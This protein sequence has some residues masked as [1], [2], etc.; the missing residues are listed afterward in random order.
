MRR[1][2]Q[3][4]AGVPGVVMTILTYGENLN[5]RPHLH[6]IVAD[7]LFERSGWFYVMGRASLK[8]L[9]ELFE[10]DV[11]ST[12]YDSL[13]DR[14]AD[15]TNQSM[16]DDPGNVFDVSDEWIEWYRMTPSERWR[17]SGTLW[18]FY[19]EAGGSLEPEPDT[20][21]PFNTALSRSPVPSFRRAGVH[22]LRR[23]GI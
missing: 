15:D 8:P 23:C 12:A 13:K 19:M 5:W 1:S 9:E 14:A 6:A 4:S 22:I 10:R 2:L 18:S 7:G 21:S 3:R 20:Q 11:Q 16:Q 17:E